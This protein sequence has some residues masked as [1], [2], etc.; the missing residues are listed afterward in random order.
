VKGST[1]TE[2]KGFRG[3]KKDVDNVEGE[4][5]RKKNNFQNFNSQTSSS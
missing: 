1:P 3:K 2:K 5:K 4:Y